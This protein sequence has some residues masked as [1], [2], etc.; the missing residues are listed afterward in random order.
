[1]VRRPP[2]PSESSASDAVLK[3]YDL[4]SAL[5]RLDVVWEAYYSSNGILSPD[6]DRLADADWPAFP[7]RAEDRAN[8]QRIDTGTSPRHPSGAI[9]QP[10]KHPADATHRTP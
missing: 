10:L 9:P 3:V 6:Q 7:A 8:M 2:P 1:L 5:R 4:P